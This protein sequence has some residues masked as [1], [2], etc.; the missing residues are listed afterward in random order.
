MAW[1]WQV[2]SGD[3]AY[4]A[5]VDAIRRLINNQAVET[6]GAAN[7]TTSYG[8]DAYLL[9]HS[10]RRTDGIMLDALIN[11]QPDSDLIPKVVN[12]L[13]A[14]RTAGRWD[15]TQE[16]VFVLLALDRY[17]N[18][19]EAETPDFVARVWLGDT[20][21]G[22]HEFGGRTTERQQTIV[23]MAYLVDSERGGPQD[24]IL[25]Q[26]GRRWPAL[27]PAGPEL[28]A[29]RSGPGAA[30]HGLRGAARATRPW[31]IPTM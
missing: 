6:A 8:D 21:A 27:L 14:H 18:T 26:G 16:N 31:T 22:E 25:E 13:L 12:G 19:F 7:F 24:L 23:P 9:L 1:I 4:A 20:Y 29:R 3:P 10:N 30:G 17:F 15:N 2:L 11:D 5:E 28:C